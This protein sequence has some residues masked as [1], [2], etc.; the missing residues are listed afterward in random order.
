MKGIQQL[1]FA[2][3]NS[4]VDDHEIRPEQGEYR[5][6]ENM[7][8]AQKGMGEG[9]M[10]ESLN[11]TIAIAMPFLDDQLQYKCIGTSED[12]PNNRI[13]FFL[14]EF[15][16]AGTR[17]DKIY[18]YDAN[19]KTTKELVESEFLGWT[20]NLEITGIQVLDDVLY[21]TDYQ[22]RY[23]RIQD[24]SQL[25]EFSYYAHEIFLPTPVTY[26]FQV[27]SQDEAITI[28]VSADIMGPMSASDILDSV[29]IQFNNDS[30]FSAEFLAVKEVN[31]EV[32]KI[33]AKTKTGNWYLSNAQLGTANYFSTNYDAIPQEAIDFTMYPIGPSSAP[34]ITPVYDPSITINSIVN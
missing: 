34:S 23:L 28:N 14:Y 3:I 27:Q 9:H 26:F 25:I 30:A 15:P 22:L 12:A 10:R 7:V 8:P 33:T 1:R 31:A 32:I 21:W 19:T 4:D 5:M 29:A 18:L 20:E 24:D 6:I 16:H 11:G 17:K 2:R 13:Y